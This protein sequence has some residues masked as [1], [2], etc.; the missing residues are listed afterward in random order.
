MTEVHVFAGPSLYGAS[1]T[2]EVVWHPPAAAG[3]MLALA[4]DK[5]K[6]VVLIDGLFG[7]S[8]SPWHKEILILLAHGIP[9]IGAASMGA[10]RAAELDRFGVVGVGAVYRSYARGTLVADDAVAL[11]HAPAALGHCPLTI[12]EVDLRA[13]LVR[14]V[15]K[16]AILPAQARAALVDIIATHYARRDGAW[17]AQLWARHA[18]PGRAPTPTVAG[19][20]QAD[21]LVAIE[22]ALETARS[23]KASPMTRRPPMPP[24]SLFISAIQPD[25]K[26]TSAQSPA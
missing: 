24:G 20:K 18:L 11:L 9:V 25:F 21:A 17:A 23:P 8:R 13:L 4:D 6:I 1:R 10:L 26:Q 15:R 2:G 12:A 19:Q 14:W 5:R 22:M 16:R 3:D 7:A